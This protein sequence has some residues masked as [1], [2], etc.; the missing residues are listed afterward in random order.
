MTARALADAV[1]QR[2]V[3]A[4]LDLLRGGDPSRIAEDLDVEAA[5][6]LRWCDLFVEGGRLRVAGRL[7]P[8]S[9]EVRDRFLELFVH[10]LLGS[11][12][13][14]RRQLDGAQDNPD[15]A[16]EV[17]R[18]L[19]TT[20]EI[21]RAAAVTSGDLPLDDKPV[22]L[23]RLV[24]EA[25]LAI[26]GGVRLAPGGDVIV[27]ADEEYLMKAVGDLVR[28]AH[29]LT[30]DG[31]TEVVVREAGWHGYVEARCAPAALPPPEARRL[32]EPDLKE[33][34][35]CVAARLFAC[36]SLV[37]AHQGSVGVRQDDAATT[38]WLS[39]PTDGPLTYLRDG[40]DSPC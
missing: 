18:V 16:A 29:D 13:R 10:E 2:R 27:I 15:V 20:A 5:D 22:S 30:D 8:T 21:M 36:R 24:A 26:G 34:R 32:F 25:A 35:P 19:A 23:R 14:I 17:D 12:G 33:G 37:V 1:V 11:L 6:L 28:V 9:F 40:E 38:L 4:V 39:V 7:D 31:G 3:S